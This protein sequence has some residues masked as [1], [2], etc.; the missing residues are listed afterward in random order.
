MFDFIVFQ[1]VY[2]PV[3]IVAALSIIFYKQNKKFVVRSIH[4]VKLFYQD[5]M[6][7][8]FVKKFRFKKFSRSRK[9]K[10]S[11]N[12]FLQQSYTEHGSSLW[13]L[14]YITKIIVKK[15]FVIIHTV[16]PGILIGVKGNRIESLKAFLKRLYGIER[17]NIKES[18]PFV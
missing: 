7:K 17:I 14:A 3:L 18:N 9:I 4:A 16:R 12:N 10:H 15:K 13:S 1:Y 2:I 5:V 8:I 6:S 11:I